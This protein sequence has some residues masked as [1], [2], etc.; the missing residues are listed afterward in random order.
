M[1]GKRRLFDL[2]TKNSQKLK[3]SEYI[4]RLPIPVAGF[5][6]SAQQVFHPE[7]SVIAGDAI[8][9]A[10]RLHDGLLPAEPHTEIMKTV[11][12]SRAMSTLSAWIDALP[13]GT[14]VLVVGGG[15]GV[16]FNGEMTWISKLPGQYVVLP[17]DK[18]QLN[19]LIDSDVDE[20]LMIAVNNASGIVV[21]AVSGIIPEEPPVDREVVF[22]LTRWG[23]QI[24]E[25]RE[26]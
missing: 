11:A 25:D 9:K 20:L 3:L 22:E 26:S 19:K 24:L 14:Y 5:M 7:V 1:H 8:S 4:E 15:S 12:R 17:N 16:C 6:K 23:I 10:G 18:V 21:E 2:A 13:G